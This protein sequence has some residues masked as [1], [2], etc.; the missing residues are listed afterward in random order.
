MNQ[1]S[2]HYYV[3]LTALCVL[4]DNTDTTPCSSS[5]RFCI[6]LCIRAAA[7][8]MLALFLWGSRKGVRDVASCVGTSVQ[9]IGRGFGWEWMTGTVPALQLVQVLTQLKKALLTLSSFNFHCMFLSVVACLEHL[10]PWVQ[11]HSSSLSQYLIEGIVDFQRIGLAEK[12]F[13]MYV[14]EQL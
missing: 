9:G 10:K 8:F 11:C 4:S 13:V 12:P 3:I 7:C 2:L 5:T 14:G 1:L 6:Y